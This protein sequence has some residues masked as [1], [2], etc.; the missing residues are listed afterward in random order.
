MVG[1][2]GC[3]LI[4]APIG[5]SSA[6]APT[7]NTSPA[8]SILPDLH[9]RASLQPVC[10]TSRKEIA[11]PRVQR[12]LIYPSDRLA[13]LLVQLNQSWYNLLSLSISRVLAVTLV[14]SLRTLIVG[15]A[16]LVIATAADPSRGDKLDGSIVGPA[17]TLLLDR[18]VTALG[19]LLQGEA[20]SGLAV[21]T[22][23]DPA[24]LPPGSREM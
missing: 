18:A 19:L 14:P 22:A 9:L 10:G 4:D 2:S 20:T 23:A 3:R 12:A 11:Q 13:L 15:L 17:K 6:D 5:R 21:G 16:R 8:I 1:E 24:P 7:H